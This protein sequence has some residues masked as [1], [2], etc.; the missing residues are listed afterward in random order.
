MYGPVT[1]LG[2]VNRRVKHIPW[3]EFKLRLSST[4]WCTIPA[5][6]I[7]VSCIYYR[8]PDWSFKIQTS[9]SSISGQQKQQPTPLAC[10]SRSRRAAF[11]MEEVRR[12][13]SRYV[14]YEEA[15][16][17]GSRSFENIIRGSRRSPVSFWRSVRILFPLFPCRSNFFLQSFIRTTSSHISNSHKVVQ[18]SNLFP[19]WS[20]V[21]LS[22]HIAHVQ[23]EL[24]F[25]AKNPGVLCCYKRRYSSWLK[26]TI[27]CYHLRHQGSLFWTFLFETRPQICCK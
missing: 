3:T 20:L 12:D 15:L 11:S 8:T 10:P 21:G 23:V 4:N 25:L 17:S 5:M 19:K 2:R 6:R 22:I 1:T 16:S 27:L 13:A 9:S 14:L 18:K 26:F 7:R 24:A